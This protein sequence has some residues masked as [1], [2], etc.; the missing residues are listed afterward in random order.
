MKPLL[1]QPLQQLRL[2]QAPVKI[3]IKGII[4]VTQTFIRHINNLLDIRRINV[5]GVP[6]GGNGGPDRGIKPVKLVDGGGGVVVAVGVAAG[7][8]GREGGAAEAAFVGVDVGGGHG[9]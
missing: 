3:T 5:N 6:V 9:C 2:G 1:R 4:Q 7:G 8:V